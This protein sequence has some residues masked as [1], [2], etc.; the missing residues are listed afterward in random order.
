MDYHKKLNFKNKTVIKQKHYYKNRKLS[1]PNG[2]ISL[3]SKWGNI[4][5]TTQR[6]PLILQLKYYPSFLYENHE[7]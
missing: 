3:P 5:A 4:F 2:D 7:L 1:Y 6:L